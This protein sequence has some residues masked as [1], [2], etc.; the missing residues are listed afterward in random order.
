MNTSSQF[1][2]PLDSN[3][4]LGMEGFNVDLSEWMKASVGSIYGR[5]FNF[6]T[7]SNL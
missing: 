7:D 2:D 5:D 4:Q 6:Q 1:Q 3:L